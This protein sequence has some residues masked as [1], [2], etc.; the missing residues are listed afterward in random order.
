M[1]FDVVAGPGRVA[2][3]QKLDWS[4]LAR[5][6]VRFEFRLEPIV[7]LTTGAHIGAEVLRG[8][9]KYPV[10][11][12]WRAWYGR[13]GA[14]QARMHADGMLFVN[15]HTDQVRDRVLVERL[16][17]GVSD[18]RRLVLE[19]TELPSSARALAEAATILKDLRTQH[20]LQVCVD[21][22]SSGMDGLQRL[23]LARPDI[24]K[25]DGP[26][27]HFAR[28]SRRARRLLRNMVYLIQDTGAKAVIEWI[29]SETD[30]A[31]AMETGADWGQGF[32]WPHAAGAI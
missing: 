5:K 6:M 11:A 9:I 25:I 32:F 4:P 3:Q 21:D 15:L 29:E 23:Q 7:N 31:I 22:L 24:V 18:P 10:L 30:M 26:C 27:L 12:A 8:G 16:L 17:A 19:W 13:L 28:T 1:N 20:G 2:L 14:L